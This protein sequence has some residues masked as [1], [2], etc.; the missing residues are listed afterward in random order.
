MKNM[1]LPT[2]LSIMLAI[3][4]TWGGF[5]VGFQAGAADQLSSMIERELDISNREIKL[6]LQE[7]DVVFNEACSLSAR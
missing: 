7:M 5:H 6:S 1:N 4:L 3:C 2:V